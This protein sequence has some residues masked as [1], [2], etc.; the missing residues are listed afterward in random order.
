MPKSEKKIKTEINKIGVTNDT[1]SGR[2]GLLFIVKYLKKINILKLL[3]KD[4][5]FLRKSKKGSALEKIF[6]QILCF[7]IDGTSFALSYFDELAKDKGYAAIIEE[8]ESDLQSSHAIK[9]FFNKFNRKLLF[10]FRKILLMLFIWRLNIERPERIIIGVDTMVLDNNEAKK[11]EGVEPTYKKVLGYQPL[12]VTC[13]KY[14]IDLLF[15]PGS[16]HSNH[17]DDLIRVIK[18]IVKKIRKN[19]SAEV[20]I[21]LRADAGFFAEENFKC[22]DKL[23]IGFI[24]GGKMYDDVKETIEKLDDDTFSEFT[25]K[26]KTW[27]YNELGSK[28]KCWDN[29]YRMIYVKPISDDDG[30]LLLEFARP[31]YV[32]FTNLGKD[33][34]VTR[35][36][37]ELRNLDEV[38]ASSLIACYHN[39]GSDEL[40]FKGV[41][42][43]GT[44]ALPFKGFAQNGAYYYLMVIAYNVFEFFKKDIES[45]VVPLTIYASIFR[46]RFIDIACKIIYTGGRIIAKVNESVFS[47]LKLQELWDKL[48]LLQISVV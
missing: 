4:F 23:G 7:F 35:K 24:V 30:Q 13:G 44:E 25:H 12:Q 11:R 6:K 40:V 15:R 42:D 5:S 34:Q 14:V 22:F 17:G 37:C 38:P 36:I 32:L 20:P 45:D 10:L 48:R 43:L 18:K 29:F 41:K 1:I 26:G 19:Y 39:R 27:Y 46:R 16:H 3:A 31:E 47:L 8:A 9:R 33:N 2:G 28:C 21:I